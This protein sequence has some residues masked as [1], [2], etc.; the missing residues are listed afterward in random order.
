[1]AALVFFCFIDDYFLFPHT[2]EDGK[3]KTLYG[4]WRKKN[5]LST[6]FDCFLFFYEEILNGEED[7]D[8]DQVDENYSER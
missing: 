7:D 2:I 5:L 1:M 8:D 4:N 6:W 3:E